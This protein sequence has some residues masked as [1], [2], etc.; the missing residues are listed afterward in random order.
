MLSRWRKQRADKIRANIAEAR[1]KD[2]DGIPEYMHEDLIK[3][4]NKTTAYAFQNVN[5]AWADC[6]DPPAKD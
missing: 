2:L 4:L 6:L 5:L 3:A 1:L